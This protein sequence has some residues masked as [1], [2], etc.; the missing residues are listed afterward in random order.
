MLLPA[1]QIIHNYHAAQYLKNRCKTVKIH[2][3]NILY[4]LN[5]GLC[6]NALAQFPYAWVGVMT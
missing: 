1:K 6:N 3:T 5:L 2:V 4:I